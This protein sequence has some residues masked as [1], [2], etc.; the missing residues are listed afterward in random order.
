M[1]ETTNRFSLFF[2]LYPHDVLM[3]VGETHHFDGQLQM[4]QGLNTAFAVKN[5]PPHPFVAG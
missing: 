2:H 3:L 4:L 1:Y 5:T